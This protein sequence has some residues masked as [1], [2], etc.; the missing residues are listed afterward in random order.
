MNTSDAFVKSLIAPSLIL[1]VILVLFFGGRAGLGPFAGDGDVD[2]EFDDTVEQPEVVYD[3]PG[4]EIE[5]AEEPVETEATKMEEAPEESTRIQSGRLDDFITLFEE[6]YAGD[7]RRM[8]HVTVDRPMYQ[9]GQVIHWRSWHL[10]PGNFSPLGD[11][12]EVTMTLVGPRDNVVEEKEMEVDAAMT[13]GAFE[14]DDEARGGEWT[15]RL[16]DGNEKYERPVLV[17][18]FEAPRFRQELDFSRR[19]YRP[20]ETVEAAIEILRDTGA[21][22]AGLEVEAHLQV[23]GTHV[24][25]DSAVLNSAGKADLSLMLPD[26]ISEDD[27]TLVVTIEE[28][29][30]IETEIFPVPLSLD[31]IKLSLHPEGGKLVNGLTSRVYFEATDLSDDPVDVEGVVFDST[32]RVVTELKTEHRGRGRFEFTPEDGQRYEIDLHRPADAEGTFRV[33]AASADGCVLRTY[34]DFDSESDAVRVGVKCADNILVGI[35]AI[36][37][38]KVVDTAMM[39]AGPDEPAVAYLRPAEGEDWP[40]PAGTVRIS[41][42]TDEDNS[43]DLSPAAERIVFRGRRAQMGVRLNFDRDVY[44]PGQTVNMEIETV[45]PDGEP[46]PAELA[47]G[48][49]DD[50]VHARA[51]HEVP[52]LVAQLLLKSDD[53]HF[54]GDVDEADEYFDLYEPDAATGLDLLTG[55]QGWRDSDELAGFFVDGGEARIRDI[56]NRPRR[57][58]VMRAAPRPAEAPQI[59]MFGGG[60]G[61]DG[62]ARGGGGLGMD[63]PARA[64][65]P[66]PADTEILET[67]GAERAEEALQESADDED[68]EAPG[69]SEPMWARDDDAAAFSAWEPLLKTGSDGR[70][71]QSFELPEAIGAYRVS[72]D[73]VANGGWV[74]TGEDVV[75]IEVPVSVALRMPEIM[76]G[77]DELMLPVT[78]RNSNPDQL[79]AEVEISA[80]GPVSVDPS[81]AS[82]EIDVPADGTAT[83]FVPVSVEDARGEGS[84]YATVQG[85]GFTDGAERTFSIEPRGY[86]RTVLLSG[87]LPG[88]MQ[89]DIPLAGMTNAGAVAEFVAYPSPIAEALEGIES[90]GRRPTGC[91]E[92]ASGSN[93]PNI[94]V[95][96]YLDDANQLER[97]T[98]SLLRDHIETGYDILSGYEIDGGGF[99]WFGNP[100]A[101][102]ALSSWGLIQFTHM[103]DIVSDFDDAILNRTVSFLRSLL[104][105]DGSWDSGNSAAWQRISVNDRTPAELLV[106]FGLARVGETEGFEVQLEEA[107]NIATD[108][109]DIYEIALATAALAYA[110]Y[111]RSVV[112]RGMERLTDAQEDNGSWS[113]PGGQSWTWGYGR[114][115]DVEVT[116]LA[117]LALIKGEGSPS[118]ITKA[119]DWIGDQK[120]ARSWWGST[121]ATVMALEARIAYDRQGFEATEG[122][123]HVSVDGETVSEVYVNTEEY[124]PVRISGLGEHLTEDTEEVAVNSEIPLEYDL[125]LDWRV[126]EFEVHGDTPLEVTM[127]IADGVPATMGDEVSVEMKIRNQTDDRL[128][129]VVARIGLPAGV[130]V[131]D[132]ELDALTDRIDA[133]IY[134][135]TGRDVILYFEDMEGGQ[136]YSLRFSATAAVAGTFEVPAYVAYPY[137]RDESHWSWGQSSRFQIHAP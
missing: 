127:N 38:D 89:H 121:Q 33:P 7:R 97:S 113:P 35:S 45:G 25:T 51:H 118:A 46:L 131:G 130:E 102:A 39:T 32:G 92:Q 52:S 75:R 61:A 98:E 16:E 85:G 36:M 111:D 24:A 132:R 91:F 30:L 114:S 119:T 54:W 136:E 65:E 134:E 77:G 63:A 120:T 17:S 74:G 6:H 21:A 19:A 81:E 2:E 83:Y 56:I 20:G 96:R 4:P 88:L 5:I 116:G 71:S 103:K 53:L 49:V 26:S 124:E 87:Q 107:A 10:A 95:W 31:E 108:S 104:A 112:Q 15:L 101:Q 110:D 40:R 73:G 57:E 106:L 22:P 82:F 117:T 122:T 48:I 72:I 43:H 18:N 84:I 1:L 59:E 9:P 62:A 11:G 93:H 34:D 8:L 42:F 64:P 67:L 94:L 47:A 12:N 3:D 60:G 76:S 14:L 135:T 109:D 128:G 80:R 69:A 133:D 126:E 58:R 37:G 78:V 55:V 123:V 29:G 66:A 79:H 86:D 44:H 28:E 129:M 115:F 137:Y 100:P 125:E 90:M 27:A 41:V 99:E 13:S 23:T 105:P 70:V 68:G 50:R